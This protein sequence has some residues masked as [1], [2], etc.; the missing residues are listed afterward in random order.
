MFHLRKIFLCRVPHARAFVGLLVILL[1]PQ[2]PLR[3]QP[4]GGVTRLT[5]SQLAQTPLVSDTS[6]WPET[7]RA[8]GEREVRMT[9]YL[10]P[11]A[12]QAGRTREFLLMRTQNA[13]CFGKMPAANEFVIVR[14]PAPGFLVTMDVPVSVRGIL[15][16]APAGP[17]GSLTQ[18]FRIDDAVRL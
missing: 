13:C 8:L 11:L 12:T 16:F 14:A 9:G 15:R 18:L 17:Q 4:V 5:F 6:S 3:A 7:I 10:L 1:A 2:N